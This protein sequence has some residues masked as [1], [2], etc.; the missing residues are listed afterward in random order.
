MD[1]VWINEMS[2][3]DTLIHVSL[4][5]CSLF[6]FLFYFE[7]IA[8]LH[9]IAFF[10]NKVDDSYSC[11]LMVLGKSQHSMANRKSE[12]RDKKTRWIG[13]R[14]RTLGYE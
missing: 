11:T 3:C 13:V 9:T 7:L 10:F 4:A 6:C 5:T 12:Q 2:S 1:Y 8:K 14:R